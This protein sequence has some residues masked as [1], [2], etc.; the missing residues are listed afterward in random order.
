MPTD[1]LADVARIVVL[2][3]NAVGDFVVALPA[4]RALRRAYPRARIVLVGAPWLARFLDGRPGPVDQV[5]PLPPVPGMV[6]TFA[7][8]AAPGDLDRLV[9]RLR[10]R[11]FDVAVQMH[12]GGAQSNP[13]VRSFGAGLT[14][15]LRTA[16]AE[17]LDRW[18]PFDYYQPEVFRC[19]ETVGL[20]GAATA[21]VEPTLEPHPADLVEADRVLGAV[22]GP[23]AA[24]HPGVSDP[25]RCWPAE[26]FAAVGDALADRGASVVVT[27]GAGEVELVDRVV[28]AMRRPGRSLAGALSLGGLAGLYRRSAVVVGND[29][30][31]LHLARAVGA[32]TVTV[33]WCGNMINVGPVT[34]TR[35][36]PQIS[37][38]LH[39]PQCGAP[40]T[41]D[42]YPHRPGNGCDHRPSFVTD[43][44]VEEVRAAAVD[45]LAGASLTGRGGR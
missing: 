13:L 21:E 22:D 19:L 28:S 32:A 6:G 33:F 14:V 44:P 9:S 36:R 37:W 41:A 27:G 23:V 10:A 35:H 5:L 24:L 12:G 38:T 15:G 2:R 45:L 3:A 31:P 30:G 25:R 7:T 26:R 29:T 42:L 8:D 17:P 4:F 20:L 34:R 16:D 11:R 39:C 43:V 18:A 1:V 40:A